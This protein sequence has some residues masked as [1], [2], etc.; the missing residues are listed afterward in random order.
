MNSNGTKFLFGTSFDPAK[1]EE[2]VPPPPTFSEEEI[3]A[4]R[5]EAHAAGRDAGRAEMNAAIERDAATALAAIGAQLTAING[6]FEEVRVAAIASGVEVVAATVRKMVPELAR[7][8][9]L[10]EIEH[11]VRD[12]LHDLY[13]EPRVVIRAHDSVIDLLQHRV[14]GMAAAAGF[15]GK[16]VL[17]GD[18]Q[19][20]EADCRVEWA[21]GGA[22]R[23]I[24]ELWRR[25][26]AAIERVTDGN[27]AP[28]SATLG[29]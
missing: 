12:T 19:F 25:I 8:N 1:V 6:R 11:L 29:N 17:F 20:A 18:E 14:D 15:M 24:G 5:A 27:A 28:S 22:E 10:A 2:D 23:N 16:I 21:D 9:G 7:R 4:A 13:D 3:A 26:D